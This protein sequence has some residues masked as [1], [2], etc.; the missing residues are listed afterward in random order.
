MEGGLQ[1]NVFFNCK[2][3]GL[4]LGLGEGALI[5]GRLCY[6]PFV[7][8]LTEGSVSLLRPLFNWFYL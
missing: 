8:K 7:E 5:S 4:Y 6:D 1:S 3:R 2:K